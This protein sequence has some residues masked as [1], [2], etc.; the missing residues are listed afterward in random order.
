MSI[1]SR[2]VFV[3]CGLLLIGFL[4]LIL[5]TALL[6][7]DSSRQ[8]AETVIRN[9]T[10]ALALE[11][12]KT[13]TQA[14]LAAAAT[15]DTVTSLLESGS[16]DREVLA[17]VMQRQ[18][19]SH[20]G[21]AG[22][23]LILEP[24]IAG[25]D[26]NHAGKEYSDTDGRFAPYF[27]NDGLEVSWLPLEFGGDG[28]SEEWYDK[29]KSL[30]QDRISEPYVYPRDGVD[31]VWITATSP[32]LE[33]TGAFLGAVTINFPLDWLQKFFNDAKI[34]QT[35]YAMLLDENGWWLSHPDKSVYGTQ[36]DEQTIANVSEM[37]ADSLYV[38]Q[39]GT[40]TAVQAIELNTLGQ[41]WFVIAKAEEEE[42]F[43]NTKAILRISFGATASLLLLSGGVM[44]LFGTSIAVPVRDLTARLRELAN[45]D[46]KSPVA[47][48][49]RIDEVGHLASVIDR[50]RQK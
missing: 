30:R 48:L 4:T 9:V 23:G 19:Q 24:D 15:A 10:Q 34:F 31:V 2:I 17:A 50:L 39:N 27:Y 32:I 42:F 49:E 46:I 29:P 25:K 44:W 38:S 8:S 11:A 12:R 43:E 18:I 13:A 28:G 47:H 41:K 40:V 35:G 37:K 45:G 21:F 36:A 22:G 20:K 26:A 1:R 3:S 6:I 16:D 14:Q 7:Q 5:I 33:D